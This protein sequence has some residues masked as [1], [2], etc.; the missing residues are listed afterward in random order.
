MHRRSNHRPSRQRVSRGGSIAPP[1]GASIPEAALVSPRRRN[2]RRQAGGL[3]L[4][5]IRRCPSLSRRSA[6]VAN[7]LGYGCVTRAPSRH[8][9]LGRL[10]DQASG[11]RREAKNGDQVDEQLRLVQRHRSSRD[12]DLRPKLTRDL[13]LPPPLR[14]CGDGR[15]ESAASA[16]LTGPRDQT[17]HLAQLGA[18]AR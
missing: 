18:D 7:R 9:M 15:C 2:P 1:D 6:S 5:G 3:S 10:R 4:D 16:G 17:A 14:V 8:R 11:S 13:S 12:S